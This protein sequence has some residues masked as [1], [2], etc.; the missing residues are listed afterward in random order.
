MSEVLKILQYC[1]NVTHLSLP[2]LAYAYSHDPDEKLNKVMQ[3]TEYLTSLLK[4][5][6]LLLL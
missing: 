3:K 6:L 1:G 4:R 5:P 2:A